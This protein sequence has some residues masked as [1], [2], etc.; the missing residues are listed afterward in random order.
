MLKL[1]DGNELG[2]IQEFCRNSIIGTRIYSY[3]LTYGFDKNFLMFWGD[4][5]GSGFKTIV[6]KFDNSMSILSTDRTDFDELKEF[7]GII[8]ADEIIT[9]KAAAEQL[10]F[11]GFDTKQGFIF[12]SDIDSLFV[13]DKPN[14]DDFREIYNLISTAIPDSFENKKD[15]YLSF[16]SDFT[17]R[18]NR[19]YA[20]AECIKNNGK[21][22]ACALTSAQSDNAALLSGIACDEEYRKYGYGKIVVLS[23]TEKLLKE[24]KKVFVIAL[25]K[26]AEGFYKHIGFKE[27]KKIAFIKRKVQYV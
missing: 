5:G 12:N 8:G 24:N 9:D 26:S 2:E 19:G 27:C 11:Y 6:A 23:L 16:L 7:I 1:L 17:Y 10:G 14:E 15:A 22:V 25:N 20:K 18:A 3:A 4:K 13:A 21:V